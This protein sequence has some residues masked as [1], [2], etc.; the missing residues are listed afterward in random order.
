M[1]VWDLNLRHLSAF[2]EIC[3][4]GSLIAAAQSVNLSQPAVT[5]A[6]ARLESQLGV[7]LFVRQ[8]SG[9]TST[10][11][12]DLIE[13]RLSRALS[14]VGSSRITS[15]QARAF[16]ALARGGSYAEASALT[17]LAA[18]TLHRSVT[19]LELA[20]SKKLVERRG[21]GIELSRKGKEVAR[22]L[23][24]ARA[25][26]GAAL[27]EIAILRGEGEARIAVGA[28]PLCR[29][30]LLPAAVI[31]FQ[32][33]R[34]NAEVVIAEGSF[35]EL[36]EPLRDGELD[37]LIGA[38]RTPSPGPD[39]AQIPLFIDNPVFICRDGHPLEM[40]GEPVTLEA[41]ARYPWVLPPRGV[42]LREQWQKLFE[43]AE[44]PIP[45]IPVE[46]GSVM[47]IRQFLL[48]TDSLTI[49]SPDQIAIE[50]QVG[51]LNIIG[52]PPD[53]LSRTIGIFTR[54]DWH[55]TAIQS[56]FIELLH[57]RSA[58]SGH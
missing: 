9:M 56:E 51:W 7:S 27:E 16:I 52:K 47:V 13:P 18:A 38:L 41:L 14:L 3:R 40:S 48:G 30:K 34:P 31:D 1:D 11:A 6:I 37:V 22:S 58:E 4:L 53:N 50:L 55:P 15:A 26:L 8:P 5:Q 21:R 35:M 29:A 23:R 2:V 45:H 33:S 17:G 24:L 44:L 12:A 46:S 49:L 10:E 39:I 54:A 19:D 42:P 57:Q 25:E 28:M 32:R 20:L 36:I 43:D